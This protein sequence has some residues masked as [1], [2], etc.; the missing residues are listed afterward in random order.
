LRDLLLAYI[1]ILKRDA[2]ARYEHDMLVWAALAPHQKNA[3]SPPKP[4]RLLRS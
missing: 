4:P 1:A 3:S 2:L